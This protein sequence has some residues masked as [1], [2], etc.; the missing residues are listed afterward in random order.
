MKTTLLL[1]LASAATAGAPPSFVSANS[2]YG[3]SNPAP[4]V[5]IY[6]LVSS[7]RGNASKPEHLPGERASSRA[8][9][10][11]AGTV[12]VGDFAAIER[13]G[14]STFAADFMLGAALA[15]QANQSE[16]DHDIQAFVSANFESY[17]D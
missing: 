4:A 13:M 12:S 9:S 5:A 10:Q 15:L 8:I 14:R 11:S 2:A 7:L 1:A 6:K 3:A 16:L 17:W